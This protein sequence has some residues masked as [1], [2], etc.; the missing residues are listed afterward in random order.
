MLPSCVDFELL[1]WQSTLPGARFKSFQAGTKQ[2]R[3][4]ELSSEFVEP[5]WCEN[6]HVGLVLEGTLEVNFNDHAIIYP[7]WSGI[8]ISPGATCAH[9]AKSLTPFV[10][11]FLVEDV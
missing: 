8:F 4:L 6:G 3:L 7:Q 10:Q 2:I 5:D 1:P 11:L 9:K